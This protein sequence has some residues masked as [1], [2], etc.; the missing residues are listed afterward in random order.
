MA[1]RTTTQRGLGWKHQQERERLLQRHREGQRC[2]WCDEPMHRQAERNWDEAGLEADHVQARSKGGVK[3]DRLLH[4]TCNRERGDGS[5]D[6]LRPAL[7]RRL[8][9][10]AG[11]SLAWGRPDTPTPVQ[12]IGAPLP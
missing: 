8:G 2:W 6:H 11:N 10:W 1:R 7:T 5:R 12:I 3:A 4:M 9:G